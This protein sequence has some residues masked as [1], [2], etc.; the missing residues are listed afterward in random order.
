[1]L[2]IAC[3]AH[4]C[5]STLPAGSAGLLVW[6]A[7][8]C[9]GSAG[10]LGWGAAPSFLLDWAAPSV[11]VVVGTMVVSAVAADD[12]LKLIC[13][14]SLTVDPLLLDFR[15]MEVVTVSVSGILLM[16]FGDGVSFRFNAGDF[17]WCCWRAGEDDLGLGV[18][19]RTVR[20]LEVET[21][22]E[23]SFRTI[24]TRLRIRR[25]V[26]YSVASSI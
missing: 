25:R 16:A 26:S 9:A 24:L 19:W 18:S 11:S 3:H 21:S 1:M 4:I 6:G 20:E 7:A 2:Q 17:V 22:G 15:V 23:R 8:R 13:V 12:W 14:A 5:S 10:L